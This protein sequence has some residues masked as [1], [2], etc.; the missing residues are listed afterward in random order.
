M[1]Y[2]NT[3]KRFREIVRVM[4]KYG[5]GYIVGNKVKSKGSPAKNLRMAF[6][7][8]GPTFIKI[9]QILSTHPEM[10]PEEYIEELSKLQN[11]AKPV[12]YDEISQLFKKEF[13]ETIDNVFL[14]FEKKPIASASIAQA[15]KAVL[16]DGTV[17][18]VKIQRPGIS[19]GMEQDITILKK[20]FKLTRAKLQDALIDPAEALDEVLEY[21][22]QELNFNNEA[23]AI[24]KFHDNNK[25]VKFVGC[26]K[27]I[28]SI[29][30]S[31]VITM[32]FIDG[33]MIND[34]ENLI[35]NGYDM[36]DIGRK[37]ALSYCKQIF[38]DGFFHGDPH[39]GNIMIEDKKIYF[40]DFGLMGTISDS[41]KASLNDMMIAVATKD[42]DK[43]MSSI[44]AIGILKGSINKDMLYDDINYL[45]STYLSL[46][47]SSI[48]I[49]Q[50]LKE[51][52][53]IAN[54]NNIRLPKDLTLLIRSMVIIE[55][56]I[57]EISPE[58]NIL[59]IAVPYVKSTNRAS[60]FPSFNDL[61]TNSLL[62]V[63]DYFE[64]TPKLS[65]V[66]TT[67][68]DGKLKIQFQHKD[69]QEPI[70]DLNKMANRMI[71]AL[72][73]GALIIGSSLI[74]NTNIGPKVFGISIIGIS[75][76]V[77]AAVMGIWLL[78][79]IIRSGKL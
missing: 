28:W 66:L 13:G 71:F 1:E 40:I 69:L 56:V 51:V 42:I 50:L 70:Q 68:L 64:I 10:L 35:D 7:E 65:R 30:S 3:S 46:P 75:G 39:P 36:N 6:E 63:K 9:G 55:G 32:N 52:S 73:A 24:E 44:L 19:E 43:M 29:T 25:D 54:R 47:L 77:F 23:K 15:Y 58:I 18:I 16:N 48:K 79:S 2:K 60:L 53:D 21:T 26:P 8:L 67:L 37:L 62:Y 34:K 5:F 78:I 14:S 20:I 41:L 49:S 31:R 38:D 74:L 27:V 72:I 11:N 17:V 33:I 12:S 57:A 61:L 59:E 4:A 76:Y 22:R 45:F